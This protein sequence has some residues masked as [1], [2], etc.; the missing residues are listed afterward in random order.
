VTDDDGN[1]ESQLITINVDPRTTTDPE[2]T[3]LTPSV[4]T[5]LSPPAVSV[6]RV[7]PFVVTTLIDL[8]MQ[9]QVAGRVDVDYFVSPATPFNAGVLG[10]PAEVLPGLG[11]KRLELTGSEYVEAGTELASS[12]FWPWIESLQTA[13]ANNEHFWPWIE[14]FAE[15]NESEKFWPWMDELK[16]AEHQENF[17]PWLDELQTAQEQQENFW[18]WL[19]ELKTT[20]QQRPENFWPWIEELQIT[21][22]RPE[23]FWPWLDESGIA[24]APGEGG[25]VEADSLSRRG[26]DEPGSRRLF[27]IEE[28]RSQEQIDEWLT[29]LDAGED[30]ETV[31]LSAGWSVF[32]TLALSAGLSEEER[33][34]RATE[35]IK[36]R[37]KKDRDSK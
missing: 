15:A 13:E 10:S 9:N 2:P 22:Q 26:H 12:N 35:T 18:P 28:K 19:D 37:K 7:D 11:Y 8:S 4:L 1:V 32:L 29:Q 20:Q 31:E 17:W 34:K 24:I 25:A 27:A 14:A 36:K 21:Q 23:N 6:P 30:V 33:R 3:T 16:T 5:P